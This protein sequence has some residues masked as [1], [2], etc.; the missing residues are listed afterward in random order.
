[1]YVA[2]VDNDQR[3][4]NKL[5]RKVEKIEA[6][7][8]KVECDGYT[9]GIQL[10]D[11]YHEKMYDI[12][13]LTIELQDANGIDVAEVIRQV[14]PNAIIIFMSRYIEYMPK[15]FHLKAFQFLLKPIDDSLMYTELM[16]AVNEYRHLGKSFVFATHNGREIIHAN[17]IIYI[18]TSYDQYKINTVDK[19]HYGNTRLLYYVKT[20]IKEHSFYQIHRSYLINLNHIVKYDRET[21]TMS[22]GDVLAI[23][24]NKYSAFQKHLLKYLDAH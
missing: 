9:S 5:V 24:R 20:T 16:R 18:E 17:D 4:V 21:V 13:I 7:D 11:N 15:T 14:K 1:M 10:I 6:E 2:V 12:V 3:Y 22:N 8:L 19:P 23:A